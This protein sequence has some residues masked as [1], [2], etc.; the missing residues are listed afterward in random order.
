MLTSATGR[1]ADTTAPTPFSSPPQ[2]TCDECHATL[3]AKDAAVH[4]HCEACHEVMAVSGEWAGG[5]AAAAA[6]AKAVARHLH[7]L[8][9]GARTATCICG[10]AMPASALAAHQAGCGAVTLPCAYCN[11]TFK[12]AA[13]TPHEVRRT[14]GGL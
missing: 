2:V 12:R 7:A 4:A 3:A 13:L 10:E 5:D 8:S 14:R 6:S 9:C 11:V 1:C